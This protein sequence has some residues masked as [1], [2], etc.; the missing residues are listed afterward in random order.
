MSERLRHHEGLDLS[1][2]REEGET[3][4]RRNFI[5][6]TMLEACGACACGDGS[7]ILLGYL[8]G[9]GLVGIAIIDIETAAF[10]DRRENKERSRTAGSRVRKMIGDEKRPKGIIN[11]QLVSEA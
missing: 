8:I 6:P 2:V 10:L 5:D 1:T 7:D 11:P 9:L 4:G 3:R